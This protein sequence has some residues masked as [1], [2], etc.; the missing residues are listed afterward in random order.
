MSRQ[1]LIAEDDLNLRDFFT[2]AFHNADFEVIVA[3]DGHQ[4]M[5]QLA[6]NLP[7]VLMV[8]VGL[9]GKNGLEIVRHIR[10]YEHSQHITHDAR[11]NIIVVTGNDLL[12]RD[13]EVQLADLFLIKPVSIHQLMALAQQLSRPL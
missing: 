6:Q 8:D 7:D 9:P 11:M 2:K 4:V 12:E 5:N 13:P 3:E 10:H 1:I